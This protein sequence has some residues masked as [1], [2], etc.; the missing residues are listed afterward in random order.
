MGVDIW[1][2]E[3]IWGCCHQAWQPVAERHRGQ[4]GLP[5]LLMACMNIYAVK[6]WQTVGNSGAQSQRD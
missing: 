5:K 6:F 1:A 4:W 3:G 2:R